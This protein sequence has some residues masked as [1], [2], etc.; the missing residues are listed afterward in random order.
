MFKLEF[1]YKPKWYQFRKQLSRFLVWAARK[2]EPKS[3]YVYAK[4]MEE[5]MK[6]QMDMMTYGEGALEIEHVPYKERGKNN[7]FNNDQ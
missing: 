4:F 3:P 2:V 1:D 7:A 5:T 6:A